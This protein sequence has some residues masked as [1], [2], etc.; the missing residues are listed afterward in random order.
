MTMYRNLQAFMADLSRSG[1]LE[2]V[3]RPFSPIVEISR[4][5][6]L[7][8]KQPGGGKALLFKRV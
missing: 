8:S 7:E 1:E 3:D 4:R 5:I 2:T 6:D